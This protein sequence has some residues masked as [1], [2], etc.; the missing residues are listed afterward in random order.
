[1]KRILTVA[2]HPDDEVLGCGGAMARHAAGGDEVYVAILGEG[3]TSRAG[4]RE[5]ADM[6]KVRGLEADA[7]RAADALGVKEVFFGGLP[8]NRFDSLPLLDVV[9]AVEKL[10]ADLSP[11][12]VYTHHGG[13]L[14]V[15]HQ[16]VARAVLTATRPKPGHCVK[17]VLAFE[18]H[19]ATEWGFGR[20]GA[21]FRPEVFVDIGGSLAAKLEALSRYPTEVC[22]FPHPRS[23]KAVEAAAVRWGSVAGFHAAE[24][25]ELIRSLR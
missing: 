13:D 21:P 2:A 12:I 20:V 23:L 8:D 17:E 9:K 1:M 10:V 7:R 19:S 18:I 22:G 14:N 25:F 3:A 5:S 4:S 24:P 11:E 6:G 15:D 16:V